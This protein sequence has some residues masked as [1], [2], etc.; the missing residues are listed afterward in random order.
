MVLLTS[1][2]VAD[3]LTRK[4]RCSV[5]GV[6]C[7]SSCPRL[8]LV[9][10][11]IAYD[12]IPDGGIFWIVRL[13]GDS[14]SGDKKRSSASGDNCSKSYLDLLAPSWI[15]YKVRYPIRDVLD[16]VIVRAFIEVRSQ[17]RSVS[18]L[19]LRLLIASFRISR[20]DWRQ[21]HMSAIDRTW[22]DAKFTCPVS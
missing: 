6:N 15:A 12:V 2:R 18:P 7:S 13:A 22:I 20:V 9:A 5:S 8:L 14:A 17:V 16:G 1:Y 10:P 21:V 4:F 19:C 3:N 11:S